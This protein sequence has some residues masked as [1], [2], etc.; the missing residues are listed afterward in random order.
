MFCVMQKIHTVSL[1]KTIILGVKNRLMPTKW[2]KFFASHKRSRTKW[3]SSFK[4]V[5]L[6]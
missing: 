2:S 6:S 3:R 4:K 1:N 5:I